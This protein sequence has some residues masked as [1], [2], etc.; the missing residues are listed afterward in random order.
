MGNR[1][2][3]AR[4]STMLVYLSTSCYA[5]ILALAMAN[6]RHIPES[7]KKLIITMLEQGLSPE[8]ISHATTFSRRTIYRIRKLWL[9]TG[10]V[11]KPA[12]EAGRPRVLRSLEVNVCAFGMFYSVTELTL[13]VSWEPNWAEARYLCQRAAPFPLHCLRHWCGWDYDHTYTTQTRL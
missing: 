11:I 10:S 3:A 8:E 7:Q 2:T 4:R 1:Q 9:S 13:I 12:L 5:N 6:F